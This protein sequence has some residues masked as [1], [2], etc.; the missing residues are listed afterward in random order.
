METSHYQQVYTLVGEK[1]A[2][3]RQEKKMSQLDLAAIVGMSRA[4][5]VNIEKGRQ[6]VSLHLLWQLADALGTD[7]ID[8]LPTK[9]EI[10]SNQVVSQL[11]IVDIAGSEEGATKLVEFL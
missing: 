7:I 9:A 5:I 6:H 8:F 11:N 4:S 10:V 3:I 1:I 2:D